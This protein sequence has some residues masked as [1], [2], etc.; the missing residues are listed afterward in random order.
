VFYSCGSCEQF[1]I[2]K[3]INK[4]DRASA[5]ELQAA[6]KTTAV[7][8]IA[9]TIAQKGTLQLTEAER[10]EILQK[11]RNE[12]ST[13]CLFLSHPLVTYIHKYYVDPKTRTPHPGKAVNCYVLTVKSSVSTMP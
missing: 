3:D 7:K 2:W 13:A 4:G 9:R 1:Q 5:D 8:D 10:K 12:I 11:K 6:F